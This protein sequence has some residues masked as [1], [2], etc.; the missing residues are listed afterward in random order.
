MTRT[1]ES[2]SVAAFN[3]QVGYNNS[4]GYWLAK[5]SWGPDWADDGLFRVRT[6]VACCSIAS[7]QPHRKRRRS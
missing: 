1:T 2:L 4:G 5:N 6:A 7:M 3:V